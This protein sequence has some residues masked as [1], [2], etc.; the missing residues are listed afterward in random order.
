MRWLLAVTLTTTS[1]FPAATLLANVAGAF[2]LGLV[3]TRVLARRGPLPASLLGTGA[4]GALTTFSTFALETVELLGTAPALAVA[5]ALAS[6]AL[7]PAAAAAGLR[8]GRVT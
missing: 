3:L 5:Y 7:G 8:V 6:L 2:L 1:G 4:L